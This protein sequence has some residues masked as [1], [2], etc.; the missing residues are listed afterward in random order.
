MALIID[1]Q[2]TNNILAVSDISLNFRIRIFYV[3][4]ALLINE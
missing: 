4:E 1:L 3:F 2:S